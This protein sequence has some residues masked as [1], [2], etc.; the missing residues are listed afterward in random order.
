LGVALAKMIH[1]PET[2]IV[3]SSDLSHYYPYD[4]AVALDRKTLTA[5]QEYDYLSMSWNFQRRTWEACGGAPI[6]AAMIAAERMGAN[7][8]RLLKYANSGDTAGDRSR[9]VGYGSAIMVRDNAKSAGQRAEAPPFTL[10]SREKTELMKIARAS[11]ETT[12]REHKQYECNA[13]GMDALLQDRAAFVTLK[14]NG[15]LRGCIGYSIPTTSL[16]NTVRDVAASAAVHDP[17]FR[18]VSTAEL[19]RLEYEITVLSPL[20]RVIDI[21]QIQIGKHGLLIKRGQNVGIFLPQVAPEEGWDLKAYLEHLC[22]KGGLPTSAWKDE[23]TDIFSFT[24]LVFGEKDLA[25]KR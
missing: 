3:A 7:D 13:G 18:P 23:E 22:E 24:G 10:G 25:A 6:V 1:G 21:K 8:A 2:L 14:E 9:V 16:C 20:R 11:V 4:T 5:L 12:V 19:S 17:R 15:Q